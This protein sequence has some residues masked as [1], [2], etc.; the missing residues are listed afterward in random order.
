MSDF[1]S[2]WLQDEGG[3]YL[4][5][6]YNN[7]E[8]SPRESRHWYLLLMPRPS[9]SMPAP[10]RHNRPFLQRVAL[11]GLSQ[12]GVNLSQWP[13]QNRRSIC[14][15]QGGTYSVINLDLELRGLSSP[16]HPIHLLYFAKTIAQPGTSTSGA[17]ME[18]LLKEWRLR[19]CRMC[20]D[21]QPQETRRQT[22]RRPWW[23]RGDPLSTPSPPGYPGHHSWTSLM[24]H[25]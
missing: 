9:L 25:H 21:G 2:L 19:E 7:S 11:R 8:T 3:V 5:V 18:A 24:E 4:Y 15:P 22:A 14:L 12:L 1:T 16:S 17:L 20:S 10:L 6:H 13:A 23:Q